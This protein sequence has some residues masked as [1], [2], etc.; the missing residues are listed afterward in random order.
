[1]IVPVVLTVLYFL[2]AYAFVP[3]INGGSLEMVVT[4][5]ATFFLF[6]LALI[7]SLGT[8]VVWGAF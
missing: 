4:Y 5:L 8:W 1:M 6:L 2:L 3:K 7:A